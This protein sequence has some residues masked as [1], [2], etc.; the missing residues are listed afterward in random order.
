MTNDNEYDRS[1]DVPAAPLD[2]IHA[3]D[4]PCDGGVCVLGVEPDVCPYR[5]A[6]GVCRYWQAHERTP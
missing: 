3:E 2:E 1:I 4:V 6:S 5:P